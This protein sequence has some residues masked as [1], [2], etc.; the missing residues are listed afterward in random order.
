MKALVLAAKKSL[1]IRQ[2]PEPEVLAGEVLIDIQAVSIGGSEYLGYN[3]PGI[4]PLPSI[5]GHGIVGTTPAGQRVA[6]YP[7]TGC[8]E[9]EYCRADQQQLCDH[10]SLIGVQRD[11]GF[12][13]RIAVP[14][15]A[16]FGLPAELSWEQ[17]VFIEPFA[18]SVNA[19]ERAG[20]AA[21]DS[22]AVIGGGSLG[23]G[24]VALARQAG[25]E[26][27]HVRDLSEQRMG[28]AERLGA[29]G[30]AGCEVNRY[31]VVFDTVGSVEARKS[32]VSITRKGGRCVFMGFAAAQ[33]QLAV[34]EVVRQQKTL[35]GAFVYSTRQFEQAITLAACCEDDW[36]TNVSFEEVEGCLNTY[37]AGNFDT[38]KAALRPNGEG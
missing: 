38:V 34:S 25:C 3:N 1:Q 6:V 20:A 23:L 27:V 24:L 17:A 9:C 19:W 29:N 35:L 22:I 5:M 12:A 36:V 31:D 7:L 2:L 13:Q 28:V 14:E 21:A 30:R 15:K 37:L 26:V 18:N 33:A 32:A 4:R 8:G 10:W 11:G 16:V